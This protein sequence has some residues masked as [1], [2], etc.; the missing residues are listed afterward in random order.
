MQTFSISKVLLIKIIF[1]H[2]KNSLQEHK[3]LEEGPCLTL[4][5]LPKAFHMRAVTEQIV[6]VCLC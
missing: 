5:T 2:F 1:V 3:H 4:S 6:P